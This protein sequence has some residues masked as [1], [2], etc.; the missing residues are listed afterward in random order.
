MVP[1]QGGADHYAEVAVLPGEGDADTLTE[2]D[3]AE[4]EEALAPVFAPP[5]RTITITL[6][7]RQTVWQGV[8]MLVVA[9]L[10]AGMLGWYFK[11]RASV[12]TAA[13][14]HVV[15]FHW[16]NGHPPVG[17]VF[18]DLQNWV[19]SPTTIHNMEV[20][21]GSARFTWHANTIRIQ[22]IQD[23]LVT[24][25]GAV[26]GWYLYAIKTVTRYAVNLGLRV[27]LNA[28]TEQSV[29]YDDEERLP[30]ETAYWQPDW[31][32]WYFWRTIATFASKAHFQKHVV[33]DLFNEPRH[34]S[35]QAWDGAFQPLV[36]HIRAAGIPNVIWV[37]GKD[38]ASTLY[39]VPLL[40]QPR[41]YPPIVYTFHHPGSTNQKIGPASPN[42]WWS[43]GLY[44]AVRGIPVVDAEFAGYIGNYH[45]AHPKVML[46]R[47]FAELTRYHVGLM[48][49]TLTPGALTG[50]TLS[51]C[52]SLPQSDGCLVKAY[53]AKT[54][55]FN[56]AQWLYR[57]RHHALNL[58]AQHR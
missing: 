19:V 38:W 28:Q 18:S 1:V 47:Y 40:H 26:N 48:A 3:V 31:R 21:I 42:L 27:V 57:H 58:A 13:P 23:K 25:D 37:E 56:S 32:T 5:R 20:K 17:P 46:P 39:G 9:A 7:R 51:T 6:P 55:H 30:D 50:P 4:I 49:W 8:A 22:I 15:L 14:A 41:G 52:S 33:F 54:S 43:T 11:T 34:C 29:G 35:W 10:C 12:D 24:L 16:P 45:W 2:I 53:W 36:S 44:L